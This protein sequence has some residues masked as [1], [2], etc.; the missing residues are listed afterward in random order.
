MNMCKMYTFKM[1]KEYRM[2][3]SLLGS[4]LLAAQFPFQ[5]A[6]TNISGFLHILEISV[7]CIYKHIIHT[8]MH[9]Y[10]DS[11]QGQIKIYLVHPSIHT[12]P[13][14][15]KVLLFFIDYLFQQCQYA[16]I[17]YFINNGI[18]IPFMQMVILGTLPIHFSSPLPPLTSWQ[19]YSY[20]VKLD[21]HILLYNDI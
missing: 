21:I 11:L 17:F 16:C 3:K 19:L 4:C 5:E 10:S 15:L 14:I 13:S 20:N 18:L 9:T 7:L 12:I 1:C 8:Y 2:K 6:T